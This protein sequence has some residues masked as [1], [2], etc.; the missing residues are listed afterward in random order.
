M[1]HDIL[2]LKKL[3]TQQVTC[4]KNC[5]NVHLSEYENFNECRF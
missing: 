5:M 2:N 3:T 1:G 4:K